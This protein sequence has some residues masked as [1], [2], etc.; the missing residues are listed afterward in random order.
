MHP[1]ERKTLC[2]CRDHGLFPERARVA[3]GVSGGVDSVSLLAALAAL[4][5][6][7]GIAELVAV[8]VDHGLRPDETAAER[9]L[10]RELAGRFSC[11][12]VCEAVDVPARREKTGESLEAA[13]RELRY[14]A[15]RRAAGDGGI[16]A[17]AH[18]ADD[19]AG[20][21]L[22]RLV[23]GTGLSGLAGMLPDNSLGV[24]RPFLCH[25]RRDIEAY[26][27]TRGLSFLYDSSN[28]DPAFLRNRVRQ[29]LV[30]FLKEHFNPAMV[31]TLCRTADILALEDDF[32]RR[33]TL[34]AL[35][36]CWRGTSGGGELALA[37][38]ASL[39]P[40]LARRV[41]DAVLW[42]VGCPA[43]MERVESIRE[44]AARGRTGARLHLPGGLRVLR[45]RE[46]L[47]FF[48]PLGRRP[49]RLA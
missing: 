32:L 44:L 34:A 33:K 15:L 1:F 16:V 12:F 28:D 11:R 38:F 17:V 43:T 8:Y 26:A 27:A 42:Q 19:Q 25:R 47:R 49:H 29:E 20:E 36:S 21:L 35:A 14:A 31:D 37:P 45:E 40:A 39:H 9:E 46:R 4:R 7:L 22:V 23:R 2:F 30:P 13:A 5:E 48:Y 6:E 3:S 10:V 18:H 41:V 24:V